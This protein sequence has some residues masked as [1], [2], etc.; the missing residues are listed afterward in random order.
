MK[1]TNTLL[2]SIAFIFALT[3]CNGLDQLMK[4]RDYELQ[5]REA[6]RYYNIKKYHKAVTLFANIQS[7]YEGTDKI[8]TIKFYTAKSYYNQGDFT[9][10]TYLFDEFRK[11][12]TRS[13][14]VEESEFLYAMSFYETSPNPELDQTPSTDG[15]EAFREY[16]TR[17]PNT[18][19]REVVDEMIEEMKRRLYLKAYVVANTYYN[20]GYYNSAIHAYRNVLKNY[21]DTPFREDILYQIVKSNYLYAKSSVHYKQRERYLNTIDAY[22]NFISEY[23]ES[24]YN[25]DVLR[26]YTT[27]Q[28]MAKLRAS[29]QHG[30]DSLTM[31]TES[32]IIERQER[33]ADKLNE[34]SDAAKVNVKETKTKAQKSVEKKLAKI[35]AKIDKERKKEEKEKLNEKASAILPTEISA[36]GEEVLEGTDVTVDKAVDEFSKKKNKE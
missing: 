10:S 34:K 7:I 27:S 36:T 20:V 33:K 19:R 4:S 24:D 18:S 15:I 16:L 9:N 6:L 5:Y 30:A 14:F 3:S 25:K 35:E 23:P 17:Y 29:K 2:V 11:V 28:R 26:L 22:Y 8:D 12:Y 13:P 1:I 21:P 32:R 31:E